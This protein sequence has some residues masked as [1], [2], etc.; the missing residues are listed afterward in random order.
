MVVVFFGKWYEQMKMIVIY[1]GGGI[2][3]GVY[4]CGWVIDVNNGFY[5]EGL[6]SLECVGI[7]LVGDLVEMCF[8]GKYLKV[9]MMKKFVGMGGFFGYLGIMD[10]VKVEKCIQDGDENVWFIYDVMV[11]QIGKEIGV[12]SVVL[13]GK[14][15]IIVLIGGLVYGKDFVFVIRLYIDWIL[16]VLVYLGENEL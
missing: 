2:I 3:V 14:V 11:Y 5:G 7:V 16:D 6:F 1:M 15:D 8:F 10:V 4:D 13:K 12:V 9:D